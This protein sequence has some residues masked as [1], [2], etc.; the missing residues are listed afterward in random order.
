MPEIQIPQSHSSEWVR[1]SGCVITAL[2]GIYHPT[3]AMK[4]EPRALLLL[5]KRSP[6]ELHPQPSFTLYCETGS[7][8]LTQ[9]V[10]A[11]QVAEITGYATK[12]GTT[13]VLNHSFVLFLGTG[14]QAGLEL[15]V[16]LSQSRVYQHTISYVRSVPICKP[17]LQ[18]TEWHRW[19]GTPRRPYTD[20]SHVLTQARCIH[21]HTH[22]HRGAEGPSNIVSLWSG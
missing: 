13:S 21:T 6:A 8:Q 9:A 12:P 18:T 5:V 16:F 10:S 4:V 2:Q 22:T 7:Y 19:T 15:S 14:S 11:P 17:A 1:N 3:L 20:R